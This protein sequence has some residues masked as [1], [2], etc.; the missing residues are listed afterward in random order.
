MRVI[1]TLSFA[2]AGALVLTATGCGGH[3]AV[4]SAQAQ[5]RA[6]AVLVADLVPGTPGRVGAGISQDFIGKLGVVSATNSDGSHHVWVY[7]GRDATPTDVRAIRTRLA[8]VPGV[9]SVRRLR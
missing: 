8:E 2:V 5:R 3:E 4:S 6:K 9:A 7:I 1:R